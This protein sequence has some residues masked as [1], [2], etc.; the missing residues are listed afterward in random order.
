MTN[1]VTT[2]SDHLYLVTKPSNPIWGN[3]P[4]GRPASSTDWHI[5]AQCFA[6]DLHAPGVRE[7]A[8]ATGLSG[9]S[10]QLSTHDW[11]AFWRV[12]IA[13]SHFRF[14][15]TNARTRPSDCYQKLWLPG[16]GFHCGVQGFAVIFTRNRKFYA[17]QSPFSVV[18]AA[19]R[20]SK[21]QLG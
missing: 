2:I 18:P 14:A 11:Y 9:I 12:P 13:G 6:H 20:L 19:N 3:T 15:T 17:M 10:T 21:L 1:R 5:F 16:A 8:P 4:H 7:T